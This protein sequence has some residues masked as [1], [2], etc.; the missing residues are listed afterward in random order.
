[1]HCTD[2]K[3]FSGPCHIIPNHAMVLASLLLG[4][5][6]DFHRSITIASSAAW[7]TDCNAGNVGCL[8]GIRLG[9]EGI[10]EKPFLREEV[11]DRMLVV[12]ADG[13]SC[14]T[15]AVSQSEMILHAIEGKKQDDRFSFSFP[16]SSQGFTACPYVEGGA[17]QQFQM[18]RERGWILQFL[19]HNVLSLSQHQRF[20]ISMNWLKKTFLPL[21]VQHFM[22]DKRLH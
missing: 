18:K 5:G 19:L 10:N 6:D 21:Q 7:D 11:A 15:D 12:T 20:L 22:R 14:V 3:K 1:M 17:W 8:N 4:G 9:L 16:G 13:G 2:M